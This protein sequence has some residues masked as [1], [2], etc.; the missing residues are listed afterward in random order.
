MKTVTYVVEG[1][2][3]FPFDML[4]YAQSF[5]ASEY[6]SGLLEGT[7][8]RKVSLRS[9]SATGIEQSKLRWASFGWT[10]KPF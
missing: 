1:S 5:P 7:Q 8:R 9:Y 4:R 2:G 6:D 10:V 3:S